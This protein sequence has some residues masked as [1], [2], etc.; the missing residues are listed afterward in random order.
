MKHNVAM[1]LH[2]AVKNLMQYDALGC[3]IVIEDTACQCNQSSGK[4]YP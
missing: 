4:D 1:L 3:N 2:S